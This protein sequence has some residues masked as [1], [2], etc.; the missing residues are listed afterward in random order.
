MPA[1]FCAFRGIGRL[2]IYYQTRFGFSGS[3]Y[4]GGMLG[5]SIYF[6]LYV[7]RSLAKQVLRVATRRGMGEGVGGLGDRGA[8]QPA[9]DPHNQRFL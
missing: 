5:V 9:G 6:C 3:W 7:A 1:L 2:L 8:L 4:C